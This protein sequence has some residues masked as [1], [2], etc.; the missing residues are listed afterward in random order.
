MAV[1]NYCEQ[2]ML[3]ADSCSDAAIVIGG[4]AY[5][6]VRFGRE[7]GMRG[8][9]VRCGDCGVVPGA[10]HHHGCDMERCPLCRRQSISCGCRWAGEEADDDDEVWDD[11]VELE[12]P[13][14]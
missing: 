12:W 7:W 5:A 3:S 13:G 4:A 1:C 11:S 14:I 2:E 10:V 6:P 9:K 8:V